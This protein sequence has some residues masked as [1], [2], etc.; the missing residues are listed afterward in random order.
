[1]DQVARLRVLAARIVR[2][3]GLVAVPKAVPDERP[4]AKHRE[5]RQADGR[6]GPEKREGAEDEKQADRLLGPEDQ[7]CEEQQHH[8]DP[9]REHDDDGEQNDRN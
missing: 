3:G 2:I 5:Q 6:V 1:M 8:H 4:Y 9:E 7:A